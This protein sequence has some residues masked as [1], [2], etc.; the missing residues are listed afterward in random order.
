MSNRFV[1]QRLN[2]SVRMFTGIPTFLYVAPNTSYITP[3]QADKESGFSLM[4]SLTLQRIK[5]FHYW[6]RIGCHVV[7]I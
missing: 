4:K 1:Y 2:G 5:S 7:A 6:K 3:A